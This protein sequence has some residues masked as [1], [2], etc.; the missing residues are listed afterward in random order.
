MG[1]SFPFSK[2]YKYLYLPKNEVIDKENI[3]IVSSVILS[4]MEL[5]TTNILIRFLIIDDNDGYR[6]RTG[7]N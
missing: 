4:S 2:K 7:R 1:M 3:H 5:E 6:I